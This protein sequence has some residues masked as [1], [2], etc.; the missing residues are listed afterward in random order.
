MVDN[1]RRMCHSSKINNIN[2]NNNIHNNNLKLQHRQQELSQVQP[3]ATLRRRQ[4]Q[5]KKQTMINTFQSEAYGQEKDI[6]EK[7]N[8]N[9]NNKN[10]I[11]K[12]KKRRAKRKRL[13]LWNEE[14]HL[15]HFTIWQ[16]YLHSF[17]L[18]TWM[19]IP[20]DPGALDANNAR[21]LLCTDDG[22]EERT[23]LSLT[24]Y[25][26]LA[27]GALLHG[28]H[29]R[30]KMFH[31]EA[32]QHLE[33][34]FDS[35]DYSVALALI[36]MSHHT[37]FWELD[38]QLSQSYLTLASGIINKL[39]AFHSDAYHRCLIMSS[40]TFSPGDNLE[41]MVKLNEELR[42]TKKLPY[43]SPVL[44]PATVSPAMQRRLRFL[45]GSSRIMTSV[46][47]AINL[48][49]GANVAA[50]GASRPTYEQ[51]L[52]FKKL[53]RALDDLEREI[54]GFIDENETWT[55]SQTNLLMFICALRAECYMCL[56]D[57]RSSL[58]WAIHFFSE[59]RKP[60]F[61][62]I[63]G[64]IVLMTRLIMDIFYRTNQFKLLSS[65]IEVIET[66]MI[67]CPSV[68]LLKD[69]YKRLLAEHMQ[70][71]AHSGPEPQT[72]TISSST[73][74]EPST[75]AMYEEGALNPN[76]CINAASSSFLSQPSFSS[77][78]SPFSQLSNSFGT[79][80]DYTD[81]LVLPRSE[82]Q[83]L[84]AVHSFSSSILSSA[85]SAPREETGLEPTQPGEV[86]DYITTSLDD[87]IISGTGS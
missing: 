53:I 49:K 28:D 13:Y 63:V 60:A 17:Q 45:T 8:G 47:A 40:I 4:K 24:M 14:T 85:W 52:I 7:T 5:N 19:A 9:F 87:I 54:P 37:M 65:Q 71:V 83:D 3:F 59:S 44:S 11:E 21:Y 55:T 61:R 1:C 18:H 42:R 36:G 46:M 72:T 74:L 12:R 38:P 57:V 43:F 75:I 56:G 58:S 69:K 26:C 48:F 6:Q 34:L 27:I 68:D 15:H 23:P 16:K 29:K 66:N 70:K 50:G 78:S 64:G 25:L 33:F 41:K 2:I 82:D 31:N 32:R 84:S 51:Q 20:V 62:Y 80:G 22:A 77:S 67:A 86:G 10:Q 79:Q 39:Q 76:S 81:D 35:T 73:T 30:H